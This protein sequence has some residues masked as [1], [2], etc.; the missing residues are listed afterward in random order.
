[1]T[2]LNVCPA[3]N[4]FYSKS[5]KNYNYKFDH[6]NIPAHKFD[7]DLFKGLDF[8]HGVGKAEETNLCSICIFAL[9]EDNPARS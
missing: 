5:I 1:M 6:F 4:T 7:E 2:I 3:S 9:L 8:L